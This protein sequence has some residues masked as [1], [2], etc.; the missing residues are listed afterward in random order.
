MLFVGC[1]EPKFKKYD[2]K[3]LGHGGGGFITTNN[4]FQPNS[5]ESVKRALLIQGAD[6]VE[7]DI[8]M[9][10]DSQLVLY[11]DRRLESS[12][13]ARGY[14]SDYTIDEVKAIDY[15]SVPTIHQQ[16][17]TLWSLSEMLDFIDSLELNVYLSLNI[18]EQEEMGGRNSSNVYHEALV[19][20]L[21]NY[22][23]AS[24]VIVEKRDS[25]FLK[26]LKELRDLGVQLYYTGELTTAV[27]PSLDSL[28]GIVSHYLDVEDQELID[29]L[30][31][32]NKGVSL[33][34]VKIRQDVFRSLKMHPDMIQTD[35]IPLA[36][37]FLQ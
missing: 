10:A 5:A 17:S 13:H 1:T 8:Q 28:D 12:T 2:I 36:K 7:V 20:L 3:V 27:M 18:Q 24:R 29:E 34:G 23:G 16:S 33:Y 26:G 25:T 21:T 32:K 19:K 37:S 30:Q 35:N 9:T 6:G 15:R 4:H 31:A 14:V 22:S 11:H